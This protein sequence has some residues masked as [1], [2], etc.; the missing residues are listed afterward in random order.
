M[1]PSEGI[2]VQDPKSP[3]PFAQRPSSAVGGRGSDPM[4]ELD[5][6]SHMPEGLERSSWER[7]VIARRK[8]LES[9]Q[10]VYT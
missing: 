3:N 5:D 8:K 7:F 6:P 2:L 9:E 10:K 4:A 1:G